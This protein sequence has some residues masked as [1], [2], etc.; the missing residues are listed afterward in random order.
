MQ[1]DNLHSEI[2]IIKSE[3]IYLRRD[4]NR[5]LEILIDNPDR[6]L[7]Q[8]MKTVEHQAESFQ[9]T[10]DKMD[11]KDFQIKIALFGSLFTFLTSVA[12]L[13]FEIG[14]RKN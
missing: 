6:A 8:R 7:T 5:M 2:A 12:V 11:E 3:I 9:K 13:I 10:F 4:V 1:R 14:F